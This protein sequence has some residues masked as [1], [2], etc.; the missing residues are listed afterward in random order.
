MH[1]GR[2]GHAVAQL[3]RGPQPGH[4]RPRLPGVLGSKCSGWQCL[5]PL[6]PTGPDYPFQGLFG[7]WREGRPAER[8]QMS[9]PATWFFSLMGYYKILS[10]VPCAIHIATGQETLIWKNYI[11]NSSERAQSPEL[12]SYQTKE[13]AVGTSL[14][15]Q[16]LRIHLP[17]QGTGFRS[18]VR[19]DLTCRGATKPV[20]HNYWACSL[21]PVSHSYWA[22]MPQLLKPTHLEPV[23]CNK[24][25][26][27]N[28]KHTYCN[29]E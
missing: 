15:V 2:Q 29:E 27:R 26:H 19:E 18:L 12:G 17:M 9:A 3:P 13:Q 4:W 10:I 5:T 11:A 28:E 22:C 8:P 25:S 16:W 21:E 24:G 6:L 23:L 14:V 20:S 1:L 7:E